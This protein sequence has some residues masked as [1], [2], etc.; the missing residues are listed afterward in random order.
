[1]TLAVG[2]ESANGIVLASD[3]RAT[4]GD[5]RGLTVV[6]DTV[7]K[8]FTPTPRVAVVM[9]GQADTGNSLMNSISSNLNSLPAANVDQVAE[10]IR[11]NGSQLFTQWFGPPQWLMGPNGPVPTPRP[12]VW[13][14]VAGFTQ[15]GQPNLSPSEVRHSLI[16][17]QV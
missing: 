10:T 1:M 5:P 8:I 3:S 2:I 14:M 12:D 17:H 15:Q 11:V 9:A 13:F 6:N 4:F 7:N 16:S